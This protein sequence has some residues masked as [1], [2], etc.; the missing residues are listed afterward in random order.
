VITHLCAAGTQVLD[1]LVLELD[2]E[3]EALI[4]R[5]GRVQIRDHQPEGID[6]LG[7]IGMWPGSQDRK[8]DEHLLHLGF[9]IIQE[10]IRVVGSEW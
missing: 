8:I 5:D 1:L 2:V 7:R 6:L 4:E 3:T 10:E 9:V